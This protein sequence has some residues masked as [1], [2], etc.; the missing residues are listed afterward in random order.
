MPAAGLTENSDERSV[1]ALLGGDNIYA[2][3]FPA[4]IQVKAGKK[5]RPFEKDL[6]ALADGDDDLHFMGAIIV[7][8]QPGN[9][10]DATVNDVI[11][12]QQRLTTLFL[13]LAGGVHAL[14]TNGKPEDAATYFRK[15]LVNKDDSISP[16]NI[17]LHPSALDRRSLN[18][19]MTDLVSLQPLA[20]QLDQF[21]LRV[22][23]VGSTGSVERIM[24]NYKEAKAFYRKQVTEGGVAR[25]K[26]LLDA[27]LGKMTMV[28]IEVKDPLSGPRIFDSLN[29]GQEPMTVG[30]LV[31]NDVFARS[32]ASGDATELSRLNAQFWDPFYRGFGDP[33]HKNFDEYF[34]PLWTHQAANRQEDRGLRG[35]S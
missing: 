14:A 19:V 35:P 1:G 33:E 18:D 6:L 28:S 17:A 9:P 32:G 12:G 2:I 34:F 20:A 23:P 10:A 29:S 22:L 5:L 21:S 13:Y 8:T 3:P 30:D 24:T 16:S 27:L 4:P 26:A 25:A 11:D 15:F 31:R 7:Y